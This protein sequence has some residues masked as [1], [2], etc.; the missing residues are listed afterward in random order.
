VDSPVPEQDIASFENTFN[1]N[2]RGA[3]FLV[4]GLVPGML[5][6]GR[7][8]IVNVTT[9]AAFEGIPGASGYSAPRPQPNHSP[10]PGH[11]NSDR[12]ECVSTVWPP[13]PTVPME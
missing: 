6:R 12:A 7:G 11:P 13:A 10:V 2:V 5:E 3:Y 4:A 8:T 9:M 1:T